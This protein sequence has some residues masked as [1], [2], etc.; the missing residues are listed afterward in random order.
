MALLA[1]PAG[2]S[3]TRTVAAAPTLPATS[4]TPV[5]RN[6]A[7]PDATYGYL[8]ADSGD[9][10][11]LNRSGCGTGYGTAVLTWTH[12]TSS[13]DH[14]GGLNQLGQMCGSGVVTSTCPFTVGSGLNSRYQG[15]E[16][17]D[18]QFSTGQ[19]AGDDGYGGGA[20]E[21]C[22][23]SSGNGGGDGTIFIWNTSLY[24]VNR[25]WS[26]AWYSGGYGANNPAFLC[27]QGVSGDRVNLAGGGQAGYCQWAEAVS[28]SLVP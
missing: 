6:Q 20:L 13:C 11:C 23:D 3:P 15:Q 19:C 27:S 2:A 4:L 16:I 14:L 8:C 25:H 5:A 17:M 9:G 22:P 10:L 1:A 28:G 7:T 24:M 12:E 21:P 26:D 18:I